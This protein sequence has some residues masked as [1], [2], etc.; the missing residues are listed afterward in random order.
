MV[1][2][3]EKVYLGVIAVLL[4]LL[5]GMA[6]MWF[7]GMRGLPSPTTLPVTTPVAG[8][9]LTEQTI[10]NLLGIKQP[11]LQT[12]NGTIVFGKTDAKKVETITLALGDSVVTTGIDVNGDGSWTIELPKTVAEHVNVTVTMQLRG[13]KTVQTVQTIVLADSSDAAQQGVETAVD[14]RSAPIEVL[15][16]RLAATLGVAEDVL[17]EQGTQLDSHFYSVGTV[18]AGPYVGDDV[19]VILTPCDGPCFDPMLWR[20]VVDPVG[21]RLLN[22]ARYNPTKQD[23]LGSLGTE[24]GVQWR[25][26]ASVV[27]DDFTISIPLLDLPKDIALSGSAYHLAVPEYPRTRFVLGTTLVSTLPMGGSEEV[28]PT[29]TA[30]LPLGTTTEGRTVYQVEDGGCIVLQRPDFTFDNY[31]IVLPFQMLSD[32]EL[33]GITWKNGTV[34]NAQY[35]HADH[36]GCGLTNCYAV[37]T[38]DILKSSTRLVEAGAT[39]NGEIIYG[40]KDPKDKEYTDFLSANGYGTDGKKLTIEELVSGH[41]IFYWKDPF[42]R[43]VRFTRADFLPQAECGKPVIYLYP[44]KAMSVHVSVGLKG[45]MSVS[46]P[47]HGAHGW[48]VMAQTDGTVVNRA[49]GKTYPNLFWEGTGVQYETP[50]QGFVIRGTETDAWLK[51]TLATIGFTTRE[52]AEFREFWV[53]RLP[54]T[55]YLFVTFVPQENFDRDAPL[56]IT[57][58]P[59]SVSRVFMEYRGLEAPISVAPLTLPKIVRKGFSVVEWGGA[60]R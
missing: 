34:N 8:E 12:A 39:S 6:G 3:R 55:P 10:E 60:L 31:D 46:E 20:A 24:Q 35:N 52:S 47:A 5:G 36:G 26:P 11:A 15:P 27:V 4:L 43:W 1:T 21:K 23:L 48:D 57:P 45:V 22:L 54:K 37:R 42:N 44:E 56:L 14:W 32:P 19:L 33:M 40:L 29:T 53:P 30:L 41:G 17:H 58:R 25:K 13:G 16:S 28:V 38:E 49:D 59:D 9:L 2:T 7:V 18:H 50:K 51:K